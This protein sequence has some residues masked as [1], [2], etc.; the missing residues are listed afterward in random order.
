[1]LR[2]IM[3]PVDGSP[4]SREAVLHG[5][6]LASQSGAILRLV[7]VGTSAAIT[8][9]VD[10]VAL[11]NDRLRQIHAQELGELYAIAAEC[12]AHST[13]KVTASLQYGPVA[14]TLIG[15]AKRH[16]VELIIMRSHG[17]KGFARAWFGSVADALIRDS[18]IPV[19]VVKTPSVA[20]ALED[21][22]A[23]K[24]ILIPLDGSLLAEQSIESAVALA[25]V[26][27]ASITLL[28]VITPS[29]RGRSLESAL[30]PAPANEVARAQHYLNTCLG[31]LERSLDIT[32]KVVIADD[33]AGAILDTAESIEADLI[34][35]ATHGR[36]TIKRV[37]IGS[38]A[39]RVV[40]ESQVSTMVIHPTLEIPD[41]QPAFLRSAAFA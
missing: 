28:K 9:G 39:D 26:N 8:G 11:E 24:R 16:N 2:N 4:F 18:G 27:G 21:A 13:V 15:Y 23:C 40:R 32:R 20:T 36:G 30:G 33:V 19:L 38:V 5:L 12:R 3:V 10:G 17:R 14:D 1:M 6:R 7:R 31:D 37:A 41:F 34:A 35:I 29:R 25:R 22:L